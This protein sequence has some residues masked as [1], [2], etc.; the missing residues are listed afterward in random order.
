MKFDCRAWPTKDN[1]HPAFR[2]ET[3]H[4]LPI[5]PIRIIYG[6]SPPSRRIEAIVDSGSPYCMFHAGICQS[7]GIRRI[8]DGIEDTLRGVVGGQSSPSSPFYFH[9]VKI[10]IGGEQFETMAGFSWNLAVGGL[11]GR[12]GFFENFRVQFDCSPYPPQLD[13][14]RIH[15]A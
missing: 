2:D 10:Q 4:W 11:L 9:K 13:I 15:R 8:E 7:L 12:R 6:H 5:L 1:P 14:E 3:F